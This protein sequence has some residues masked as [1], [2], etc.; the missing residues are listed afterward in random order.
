[1]NLQAIW[2][3]HYRARSFPQF[4]YL[5]YTKSGDL[6]FNAE[7]PL[8]PAFCVEINFA[9][10]FRATFGKL[11]GQFKAAVNQS[12]DAMKYVSADD[13]STKL[14]DEKISKYRA[15]NIC[16]I[17]IASMDSYRKN[18]GKSAH[19]I[20]AEKTMPN[21]RTYYRFNAAIRFYFAWVE[22]FFSRIVDETRGG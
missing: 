20:F 19:S 17:L 11:F 10:E 14:V 2:E 1:M 12:V 22:K 4:K 15:Q 7:Y 21:G 13:L 18:F 9:D 8:E 5:L 16:D 3:K 6:L